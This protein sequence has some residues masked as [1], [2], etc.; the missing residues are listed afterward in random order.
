MDDDAAAYGDAIADV[1]DE[2]HDRISFLAPG[3]AVDL[4]AELAGSGPALEIGVGTGR[5][6]LP[7]AARGLEVHG[8]DVSRGMLER[9]RAKDARGAVHT[10]QGDFRAA[11]LGQRFT[12][13]F[14]A[15]NTLFSFLGQDDQI[16]CF[17]NAFRH[18]LPGGVFLAEAY[19]PNVPRESSSKI[20]LFAQLDS[21]IILEASRQNVATQRIDTQ[22]LL[23]SESG[24]RIVPYRTRYAWPSEL[25]LMARLTGFRLRERWGTWTKGPFSAASSDHIS[26]YER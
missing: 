16:A 10:I 12:L 14:A 2:W 13:I 18:L 3:A 11:R 20:S 17:E 22:I 1:Y 21:G 8:I 19:V 4:L 25:D 5:L 9:L 23:L 7:L 26:L 6:A 15:F 24:V